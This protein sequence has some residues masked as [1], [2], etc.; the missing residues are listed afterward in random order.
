MTEVLALASTTSGAAMR[1]RRTLAV[2]AAVAAGTLIATAA[3]ADARATAP[4]LTRAAAKQPV[5]VGYGGA[6]ST[7]DL[8][9]TRAAIE[10]LRAGGNAADA[11]VAAAAT[12]GVTE[13]F[14]SGIGGGG[15]FVYYD[16]R[17][18]R[19]STIDG[20]ETAPAAFREDIFVDPATGLPYPSATAITSGLSV[21]VPGTP[22]TWQAVARRFGSKPVAQLLRPAIRVAERGFVVDQTFHDQ[23]ANNAARFA[24]FTSTSALYLRGGEP[25]AVGSVFRN[26]DLA[27]TYRQLAR[28]GLNS[29]Y[30]GPLAD[31]MAG[32][33]QQPP[34]VPGTA[35]VLPGVL[36][37]Q[38]IRGY[39]VV[40]HRPTHVS[41]RGLDVYSIAP[42]SS[43]GT[44]VGEALN[45]LENVN[46]KKVGEAQALHDYLEASRRAYADRNRYIGDPAYLDASGRHAMRQLLTQAYADERFCTIDQ[47]QAAPGPVPP[48]TPDGSYDPSCRTITNPDGRPA[49]NARGLSTTHLVVADK[50]GDVAS[51]TLTIEQI[52]GNG[53]VVPGRGFLLNNEMTDFN[54]TRLT[55]GV[56]DP[57]LPAAG[58]RP[59]SS[60]SP[61][62]V[63]RHGAPFLAL[64]TPGGA[65]IITTVLQTL[66]NR[67]DLGYSLPGAIAAPRASQ[68]NQATGA[69]EA[70]PAFLASS[71]GMVLQDRYGQRFT[72]NP[73]IGAATGLE[74]LGHGLVLAAAEPVRRGGGSALVV[75]PRR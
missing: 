2:S 16:A 48:G 58:K 17:K 39:S 13:P 22:A 25:P 55:P 36:T 41:Y 60:M 56:P 66:I 73:E 31:E 33:A 11:A 40:S 59:R 27:A 75:H 63:L 15:Y 46:L 14:S 32:T 8:D 74:F 52:G 12:L 71:V 45:I 67:I 30:T 7:V 21:G 64:G 72:A 19:I 47:D 37:A 43:G 24:K 65:S 18:H 57:N 6:A 20:R 23:V 50:R 54:F 62:I 44:T 26:P 70:E 38:D 3:P 61:T 49:G 53:M 29:F 28:K 35:P 1:T 4:S 51:Y 69:G 5:A 42:S 9:A 34:L 10:V 68:R